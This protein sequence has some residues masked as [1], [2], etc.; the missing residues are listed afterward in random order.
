MLFDRFLLR[1]I[2][3]FLIALIVGIWDFI[4]DPCYMLRILAFNNKVSLTLCCTL[5]AFISNSMKHYLTTV[6][7]R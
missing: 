5:V 4:I 1:P 3:F 2:G 6:S 7:L